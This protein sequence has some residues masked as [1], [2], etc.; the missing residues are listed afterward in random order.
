MSDHGIFYNEAHYLSFGHCT[1]QLTYGDDK[2]FTEQLKFKRFEENCPIYVQLVDIYDHPDPS[3]LQSFNSIQVTYHNAHE[4]P[5][6][7][8]IDK[9]AVIIKPRFNAMNGK[10]KQ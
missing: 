4:K 5:M 3:M 7:T 8:G 6:A 1:D 2:V 10:N 9:T